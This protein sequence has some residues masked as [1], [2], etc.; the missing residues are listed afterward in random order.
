MSL[1]EELP[2]LNLELQSLSLTH[3]SVTDNLN[4]EESARENKVELM[5]INQQDGTFELKY[6]DK[7]THHMNIHLELTAIMHS[8]DNVD[9]ET[10]ED[11][12]QSD[13]VEDLA[14]PLLNE[15][16]HIISFVTSKT[17]FMPMIVPPILGDMNP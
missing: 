4:D 10:L 3:L 12:I 5:D 8:D 7:L 17:D 14:L 1:S 16:S 11:I 13:K 6:T 15:A 9:R 2:D